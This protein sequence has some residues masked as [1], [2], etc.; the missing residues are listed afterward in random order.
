MAKKFK[1][2]YTGSANRAGK[3]D[4]RRDSQVDER[5]LARN[6]CRTFGHP[7]DFNTEVCKQCGMTREAVAEAGESER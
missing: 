2:Y 6:W 3:G 1:R 7:L 4:D 5:I